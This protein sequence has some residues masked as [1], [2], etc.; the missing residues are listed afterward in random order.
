MLLGIGVLLLWSTY[1]HLTTNNQIA[2]KIASFDGI[3]VFTPEWGVVAISQP[4]TR[5]PLGYIARPRARYYLPINKSN[6]KTTRTTD[7][8]SRQSI[9]TCTYSNSRW[10]G[11]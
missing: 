4:K 1:L 6:L 5:Q 7:N 8:T 3:K 9:P 11:R 2:R 10:S